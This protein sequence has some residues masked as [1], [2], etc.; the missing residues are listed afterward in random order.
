MLTPIGVGKNAKGERIGGGGLLQ[1]EYID[2]V[3]ALF[4]GDIFGALSSGL[5]LPIRVRNRGGEAKVA[6]NGWL[7]NGGESAYREYKDKIKNG[8]LTVE[9]KDAEYNKFAKEL[10]DLVGIWNQRYKILDDRPEQMLA[11]QRMIMGFLSDEWNDS[12]K[13]IVSAY[14]AAG[15]DALGGFDRKTDETEEEYE[16]RKARVQSAY[17]AQLDKEYAAR[18]VLE[19]IGFDVGG[20][21]YED[22]KTKQNKDREHI[23]FQ[24]K[25][26]V[27]GEIAGQTNLKT[28]Y[29][30]YSERIRQARAA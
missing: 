4:D 14:R 16:E 20:Y 8:N 10:A 27:E 23:N 18:K 21:D 25:K 24:F 30:D 22:A 9:E 2:M 15:I 17:G 6:M 12:E 29:R 26:L 5:E 11:A 13:R 28:T 1:H 3:T 19:S 7:K